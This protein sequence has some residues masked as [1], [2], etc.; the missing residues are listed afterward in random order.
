MLKRQGIALDRSTLSAW[1]GRACW[2]LTPVYDLV[3][4]T[5]LSSDKVFAD[6]TTLPVL[7]PGRGKTKTGRLWTSYR[8]STFQMQVWPV[9]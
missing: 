7:D 1:V 5:V 4:S 9:L 2:W 3:L 8:L 6:E